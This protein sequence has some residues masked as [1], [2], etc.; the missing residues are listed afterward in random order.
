MLSLRLTPSLAM[1]VLV[2]GFVAA[3]SLTAHDA[4]GVEPTGSEVTV[5]ISEPVTRLEKKPVP[6][7]DRWVA[8]MAGYRLTARFGA[9]GLWS[10]DH[11]GLDLAAPSGTSIRSVTSGV[12]VEAGY[13]GAYGQKTV[14]RTA[15]G[16]E[17]WYCHQD[18]MLVSV[19]QRVMPGDVIGTVGSTGNVTG[20]HLHLEVRPSP[21]TP[22][23]PYSALAAHGLHL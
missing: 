16:I 18:T 20:P 5:P 2:A 8:P 3:L 23:D 7:A 11:T 6:L 21:D 1:P 13:D 14:V 22:V 4:H 10:A 19:G 12:I 15:A 9:S 17:L